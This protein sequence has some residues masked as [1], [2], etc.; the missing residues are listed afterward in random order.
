[1]VMVRLTLPAVT[2]VV[3]ENVQGLFDDLR[4]CTITDKLAH[5]LKGGYIFDCVITQQIT[6]GV[7]TLDTQRQNIYIYMRFPPK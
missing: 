7:I 5:H 1:M 6:R 2:H 3:T 4:L